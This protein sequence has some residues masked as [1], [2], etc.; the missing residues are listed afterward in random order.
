MA[1]VVW[2]KI[3]TSALLIGQVILGWQTEP[4]CNGHSKK[5][6]IWPRTFFTNEWLLT[7][8]LSRPVEV[9]NQ[10][11]KLPLQLHN[12]LSVHG[13]P[14]C[15]YNELTEPAVAR[16]ENKTSSN[17]SRGVTLGSFR[18]AGLTVCSLLPLTGHN[19]C[20]FCM[21]L[22]KLGGNYFGGKLQSHALNVAWTL[23]KCLL[24]AGQP[25]QSE[26]MRSLTP[27]VGHWTL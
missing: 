13:W 18:P 25:G 6:R 23:P 7:A 3:Q 9:S 21:S 8:W 10:T 20:H 17:R 11:N 15:L 24:G 1:A 26:S 14:E 19:Y 4:S 12:Q 5:C 2:I 22:A 16:A 27:D